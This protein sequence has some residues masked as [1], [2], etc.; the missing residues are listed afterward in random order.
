MTLR[1]GPQTGSS[2]PTPGSL[3]EGLA[4]GRRPFCSAGGMCCEGRG[5]SGAEEHLVGVGLWCPPSAPQAPTGK[6]KVWPARE[7]EAKEGSRQGRAVLGMRERPLTNRKGRRPAHISRH[8]QFPAT[9]SGTSGMGCYERP[10]PS[11]YAGQAAPAA[12]IMF[13]T[14]SGPAGRPIDSRPVQTSAPSQLELAGRLRRRRTKPR[15]PKTRSGGQVSPAPQ[16][17][18]AWA[19][20]FDALWGGQRASR[21]CSMQPPLPRAKSL[22]LV[23]QK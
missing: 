7:N 8:P 13:P 1:D 2:E 5:L 23:K 18:A 10:E 16:R 19:G 22:S 21:R 6:C 11:H 20:P 15:R 9:P 3:G 4:G 12:P 17:T 14:R